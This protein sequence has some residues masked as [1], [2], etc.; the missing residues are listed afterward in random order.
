MESIGQRIRA[1]RREKGIAVKALAQAVG[2]TPSAI[3]ELEH[4]RVKTSTVLHR[5]AAELGVSV[6]WLD[7]GTGAKYRVEQPA[8]TYSTDTRPMFQIMADAVNLL[9]EHLAIRDEPPSW[10]AD[11]A[12][13]QLAYRVAEAHGR[14]VTPTDL[15]ELTKQLT[16]LR[17]DAA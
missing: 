15:L 12:L 13:L 11:P 4:G 14:P 17:K 10:V 7:T 1:L 16:N 2:V 5:I 6:A 3:S 9:R 8:A